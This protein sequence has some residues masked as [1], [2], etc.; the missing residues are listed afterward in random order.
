M[1]TG[2]YS[3]GHYFVHSSIH[4]IPPPNKT[5]VNISYATDSTAAPISNSI[6]NVNPTSVEPLHTQILCQ[7]WMRKV[8][9]LF[10]YHTWTVLAYQVLPP[11]LGIQKYGKRW[12]HG[13]ETTFRFRCL[14]CNVRQSWRGTK[15]ND[16]YVLDEI[17]KDARSRLRTDLKVGYQTAGRI[18]VKLTLKPFLATLH[19]SPPTT[20]YY[21][22][23]TWGQEL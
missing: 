13:T 17:V 22:A 19:S 6:G 21:Q 16:N 4:G 7:T 8:L 18:G 23:P 3:C 10:I 5:T 9:S 12:P 14:I 11:Q 2:L 15:A 1:A 20:K